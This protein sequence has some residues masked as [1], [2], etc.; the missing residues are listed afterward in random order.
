M[1]RTY[2]SLIYL[3]LITFTFSIEVP[4]ITLIEK[5]YVINSDTLLQ[6]T[7]NMGSDSLIVADST[8]IIDSTSIIDSIKVAVPDT[9]K[10]IFMKKMISS[11]GNERVLSYKQRRETDYKYT[12]HLISNLPFGF[13]NDLGSMGYPSE[14]FIYG[15]GNG[16]ISYL[17]NDIQINNRLSN[18]IDLHLFPSEA[19]DSLILLPLTRGFLTNIFNNPVSVNFITQDRID[20]VPYSRIRYLQAPDDEGFIDAMFSAYVT[21]RLNVFVEIS[22]MSKSTTY[23]NSDYGI[24]TGNFRVRY[25]PSNSLNVLF[26]YSHNSVNTPLNGGVAVN[27]ITSGDINETLYDEVLAPVNY[28]DR[29]QKQ[30]INNFSVQILGSFIDNLPSTISLYYQKGLSEFR[31]NEKDSYTDELVLLND[32]TYKLF[33]TS[34][35]Q[36]LNTDFA[37]LD[38][39]ASWENYT[40]QTPLF[41]NEKTSNSLSVAGIASL[42]IFDNTIVPNFFAKYLV[43]DETSYLGTGADISLNLSSSLKLYGGVSGFAKPYT[44]LEK[45]LAET[46]KSSSKLY[47]VEAGLKYQSSDVKLALSLV[48]YKED[49]RLVPLGIIPTDSTKTTMVGKYITENINRGG[50]N[51]SASLKLWQILFEMNSSYYFSDRDKSIY[52]PNYTVTGGLYYTDILFNDNLQLKTGLNCYLYGDRYLTEYDFEKSVSYRQIFTNDGT[53]SFINSEVFSPSF[54]MDFFMAGTI[55]ESATLYFTFEN[56][57]G[58]NYFIAPYYPMK[59]RYFR[60]GVSWEFQN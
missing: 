53:T 59:G 57:L 41:E 21:N 33:G 60:F 15:M 5:D 11:E 23:D 39:I 30:T 46:D 4:G 28:E 32:N 22:N 6:T 16:Y 35:N 19:I 10:P 49:E 9:L 31:Q 55:Q 24:W 51:F 18:S 40:Y 34:F 3:L 13:L 20:L 1:K 26:N 42:K 44:L 8:A 27:D 52:T 56:L 47:I 12:G 43:F 25:M 17:K 50:V 37:D 7:I 45:E 58:E 36:S 14:A 2:F 48:N 29:Y 54:R 38:V